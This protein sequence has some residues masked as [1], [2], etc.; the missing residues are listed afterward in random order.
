M[1]SGA[2]ES[3]WCARGAVSVRYGA[4]PTATASRLPTGS[5]TSRR[6]FGPSVDVV[7]VKYVLHHMAPAEQSRV[8]PNLAEVLAPEGKLLVLEASVGT[9]ATDRASFGHSQA[10]H[11]A[12]PQQA[13]AEPYRS[14]S[15]RFY[16]ASVQ[17]QAMLMCLED[18]FGHVLLPGP[19]PEGMAPMPLPYSY[20]SRMDA[21]RLAAEANLQIDR[22][23]SAVLGLP[24]SLKYGPP[25]SV[26]VFQRSAVAT[27]LPLDRTCDTAGSPSDWRHARRCCPCQKKD[28]SYGLRTPHP[29]I[30]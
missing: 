6:L 11:P 17:H 21:T 26:W 9:D 13:W 8:M 30:P 1:V 23:R 20:L 7:I 15:G 24:P 12:W 25:S 2:T 18:T 5:G 28:D 19:G 29:V 16:Q 4:S 10:E 14:W 22:E 27:A 3:S